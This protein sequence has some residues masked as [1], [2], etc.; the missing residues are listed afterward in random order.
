MNDMNVGRRVQADIAELPKKV[1]TYQL[2]Y[3]V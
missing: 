1:G 3:L 2:R